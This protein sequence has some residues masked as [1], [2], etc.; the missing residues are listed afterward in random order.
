[1]GLLII[2]FFIF[3][4]SISS[5][6][7]E[8]QYEKMYNLR[9][10]VVY[11]FPESVEKLVERGYIIEAVG[12]DYDETVPTTTDCKHVESYPFICTG[13]WPDIDC[14]EIEFRDFVVFPPDP[15]GF[16]LDQDGI[17]CESSYYESY[18]R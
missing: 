10:D 2:P 9:L 6:Y 12:L 17:G 14:I 1:M 8:P 13:G 18:A 15:Y 5:V 11:V 7:A 4:S 3:L 16:D